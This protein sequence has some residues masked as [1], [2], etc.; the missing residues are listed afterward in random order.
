MVATMTMARTPSRVVAAACSAVV[1]GAIIV[2]EAQVA[3]TVAGP[4][5]GMIR[6][7]EREART[8]TALTLI[9][10]RLVPFMTV[11]AIMPMFESLTLVLVVM[12][13]TSTSGR[14]LLSL[15]SM[16]SALAIHF[17][18]TILLEICFIKAYQELES[19]IAEVAWRAAVGSAVESSL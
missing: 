12:P 15:V 8:E 3:S 4:R 6:S 18:L 10:M 2:H 13:S 17:A 19:V 9:A 7:R 11:T 14:S 5:T 1:V 16:Y